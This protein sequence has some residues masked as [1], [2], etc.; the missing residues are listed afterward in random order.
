MTITGI[1]DYT[2]ALPIEYILRCVCSRRYV[3][4][5]GA[6]RLI[7]DS[8]SRARSRAGQMHA[9]FIDSREPPFMNCECD[10]GLDFTIAKACSDTELSTSSQNA[11]D[12]RTRRP[13][14]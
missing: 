2:G 14:P 7:G 1:P 11:R 4:Y 12:G 5:T 3:I 6:G 10:E 8:E 13:S 9:R